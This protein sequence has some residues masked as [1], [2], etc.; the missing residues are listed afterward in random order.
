MSAHETLETVANQSVDQL[1]VASEYFGWIES[2]SWALSSSVKAG[3]EIHAS[4][5]AGVINYLCNDYGS[6]LEDEVK[7]LSNELSDTSLSE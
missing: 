3:H 2:L 6:I 5:L 1:K 7:R 4:Q